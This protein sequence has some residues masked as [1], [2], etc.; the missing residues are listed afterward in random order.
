MRLAN[1]SPRLDDGSR[2]KAHGRP[3]PGSGAPA[4]GADTAADAD[5]GQGMRR[6]PLPEARPALHLPL[7]TK[8]IGKGHLSG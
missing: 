4:G 6:P 7:P 2:R 5:G 8:T 1:G 3:L